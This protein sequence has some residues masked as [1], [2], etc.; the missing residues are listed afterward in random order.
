MT[1]ISP[2]RRAFLKAA[3]AAGG[4]LVIGV[5]LPVDGVRAQ[6]GTFEPN[7]WVKI[8]ADNSVRITSTGSGCGHGRIRI[9]CL[10]TTT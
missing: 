7:V 5:Y 8:G 6:R 1:P 2:T 3:A 10:P 9:P 4:G